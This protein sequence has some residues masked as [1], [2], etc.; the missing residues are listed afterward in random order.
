MLFLIVNLQLFHTPTAITNGM[1]ADFKG[2]LITAEAGAENCLHR[3]EW[4]CENCAS[5]LIRAKNSTP[6]NDVIVKSDNTI[7]FTDPN[8]GALG[9]GS[10]SSLQDC[11]LPNAV[12]RF[13]QRAKKSILL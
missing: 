13:I 6:P 5:L 9:F 3:T 10:L 4:F 1:T 11:E 2:R 8:Y 12:Y 7:W